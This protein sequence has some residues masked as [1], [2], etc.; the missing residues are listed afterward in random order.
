[1]VRRITMNNEEVS[2]RNIYVS[3]TCP[4]CT[5]TYNVQ[6]KTTTLRKN[7]NCG[8]GTFHF[9]VTPMRG[10]IDIGISYQ[11]ANGQVV[12]IDANDITIEKG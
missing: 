1:M 10:V 4:S 2:I 7:C 8:G 11:F 12:E 6:M 5:K 3:V 9:T